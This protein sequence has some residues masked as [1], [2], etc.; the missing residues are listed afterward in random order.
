MLGVD[1]RMRVA[2]RL[3]ALEP[4][5]QRADRHDDVELVA[6][7]RRERERGRA[8]A[9]HRRGLVEQADRVEDRG[10]DREDAAAGD[11][12]HRTLLDARGA[13]QEDLQVIE[14]AGVGQSEGAAHL[15]LNYRA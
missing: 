11:E 12:A 9:E 3:R 6:G 5:Q 14:G 4:L 2:A 7:R 8:Q 15:L 1:I 10:V 13:R